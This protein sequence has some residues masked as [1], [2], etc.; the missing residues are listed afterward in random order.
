MLQKKMYHESFEAHICIYHHENTPIQYTE[1][2]L[3]VKMKIFT[4]KNDMFLI[5]AQ[6]IDRG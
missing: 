2:V 1:N 5:F 3:V 6:N 4:G